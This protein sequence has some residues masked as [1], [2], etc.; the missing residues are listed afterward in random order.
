MNTTF[1][2]TYK[3]NPKTKISAILRSTNETTIRK[4]F[5]L[6]FRRY[7]Y[8]EII[9]I[10][11]NYTVESGREIENITAFAYNPFKVGGDKMHCR[12][13]N[14]TNV[15]AEMKSLARYMKKRYENFFGHP[16]KVLNLPICF[17]TLNFPFYRFICSIT[18]F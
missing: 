10:N 3:N 4:L 5:E 14:E 16:L 15:D 9:I 17:E 8:L 7:K 1:P 11:I 13:L 18:R 2:S 12:I 6:G